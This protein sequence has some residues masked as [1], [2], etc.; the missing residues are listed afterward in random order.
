MLGDFGG[1]GMAMAFG[2][3]AALLHAERT[4]EG[5]VIDA[6]IVDGTALLTGMLQSL[7]ATGRWNAPRGHNVADGGAPYYGTFGTSDGKWM[8]VGAIEPQFFAQLVHGLGLD[9][10]LP[11][12]TQLD[13]NSWPDQRRLI[14]DAFAQR[15]RAEWVGVFEGTDACVAPVLSPLEAAA[16]P[17]MVARGSFRGHDGVLHPAPAPR[18]QGTPGAWPGPVPAAGEHTREILEMTGRT[19]AE[20]DALIA[21]GAAAQG[22]RPR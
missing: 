16:D 17:H 1:G 15:T 18:L 19:V 21:S 2:I 7:L 22:Y 11:L 6:A 20:I 10:D 13:R 14:A 5:Q 3:A 9:D 8:A 4:S 12:S